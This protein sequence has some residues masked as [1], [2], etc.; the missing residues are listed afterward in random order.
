LGETGASKAFILTEGRGR[1]YKELRRTVIPQSNTET[2]HTNDWKVE[3]YT[4]KSIEGLNFYGTH[5]RFTRINAIFSVTK[6]NLTVELP[7]DP[8]ER[9]H[10]L[11]R[12]IQLELSKPLFS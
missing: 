4:A 9:C 3:N 10:A 8:E 1:I 11:P 6:I 5:I 12:T 7:E 2:E